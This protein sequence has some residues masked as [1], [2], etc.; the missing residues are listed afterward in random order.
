[1]VLFIFPFD[2]FTSHLHFKTLSL[3]GTSTIALLVL[4]QHATGQTLRASAPKC[5]DHHRRRNGGNL[6]S[7][8]LF[9]SF[10]PFGMCGWDLDPLFWVTSDIRDGC[11]LACPLPYLPRLSVLVRL[12]FLR[13]EEDK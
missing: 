13:E 12:R 7:V 6:S 3:K 2:F 10:F 4:Y 5:E 8:S 1:M 9:F 11:L